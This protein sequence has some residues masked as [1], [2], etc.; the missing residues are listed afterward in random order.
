MISTIDRSLIS[1]IKKYINQITISFNNTIF[2]CREIL[3]SVF[4]RRFLTTPVTLPR[5]V[6][7]K[8]V[9]WRDCITC[10]GVISRPFA[11]DFHDYGSDNGITCMKG[12]WSYNFLPRGEEFCFMFFLISYW[13]TCSAIY[14]TSFS[15]SSMRQPW[16]RNPPLHLSFSSWM[17]RLRNLGFWCS[18]AGY[19]LI[20]RC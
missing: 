20:N 9:D 19:I 8:T 5:R 10:P 13:V 11:V 6:S 15:R 2:Y 18:D 1:K 14:R 7:S 16:T 17:C 3:C 12:L 4:P